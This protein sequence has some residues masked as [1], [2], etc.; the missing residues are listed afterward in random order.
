MAPKRICTRR[1]LDP[2]PPKVVENPE[3]ILRRSK[4]K[5]DK[6]IFHLQKS[7]SLPAK[8]VRSIENI[9]LDKETDQALLRSKSTSELSQV[10]IGP[11]GLNF[12]IFAQHPSQPSS[13]PFF[14]QNQDT[15]SV[16]I[17]VTYSP[18]FCIPPLV[19]IPTFPIHSVIFPNPPRVVATEFTPLVLPTQ[20]HDLPQGYSQRIRTYGPE[21]YITTQ[22]HLDRFNDFCDLEEVDYEHAKTRLFAQSFYGEL[23]KWC[24]SLEAGSIHDFQEFEVVFLRKW[25]RRKNSLH[26]LT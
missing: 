1:Y 8:S 3:R 24:R 13:P 5:D 26:L 2:N 17:H 10:T 25:E 7:L 11:G 9:I 6:G 14:P 12:P 23:K 22:Q 15:Q 19:H 16:H 4:I 20:L 18:T 21:G